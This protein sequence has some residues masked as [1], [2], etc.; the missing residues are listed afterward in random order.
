M[1]L[2]LSNVNEF[3]DC[4][5]KLNRRMLILPGNLQFLISLFCT[6]WDNKHAHEIASKDNSIVTL[7]T[8][9]CTQHS[10][11]CQLKLKLTKEEVLTGFSFEMHRNDALLGSLMSTYV[12]C[13]HQNYYMQWDV[14]YQKSCIIRR[15]DKRYNYARIWIF[16]VTKKR[17]SPASSYIDYR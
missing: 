14:V 1:Q 11:R 3:M 16:Y 13:H 5:M 15:H 2:V 6:F 17:R 7:Y 4:R 10:R 8:S 12:S 9:I